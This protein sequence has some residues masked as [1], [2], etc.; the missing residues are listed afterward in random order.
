MSK[1]YPRMNICNIAVDASHMLEDDSLLS[2]LHEMTTGCHEQA[3]GT[4]TEERWSEGGQKRT[5]L[6]V[7]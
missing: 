6:L 2:L 5:V 7:T 4:I 1:H 3:L